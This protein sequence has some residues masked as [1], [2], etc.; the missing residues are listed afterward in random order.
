MKKINLF[1]LFFIA[2]L[3][4]FAQNSDLNQLNASAK[5]QFVTPEALDKIQHDLKYFDEH[6]VSKE[7]QE[8]LL[9]TYRAVANSYSLNNHFKQ[10]YGVYQNYLSLKEKFL[11]DEKSAAIAKL[12]NDIGQKQQKDE[13]EL[14]SLQ[15]QV[16]QLQL[17]NENLLSKKKSFKQYFSLSIIALTI[18]FAF[19]LFQTGMKL[20]KLNH[21][22]KSGRERLKSIHRIASSGKFRSGILF[23]M[24]SLFTS[25]KNL[26]SEN[27]VQIDKLSGMSGEK[28]S[29][30]T[31]LR[32]Q[33]NELNQIIQ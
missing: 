29:D 2:A 20:K 18:L 33:L 25:V 1:F 3:K 21:G 31:N 24:K 17:D 27:N 15:N 8:L 10:G 28:N 16:M 11:A 32:K 19:M 9:D 5:N 4:L 26:S 13:S 7:Q 22:L 23:I 12:N 6:P 14:V 30:I